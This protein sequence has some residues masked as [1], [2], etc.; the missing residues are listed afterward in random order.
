MGYGAGRGPAALLGAQG[1][2]GRRS[3]ALDGGRLYRRLAAPVQRRSWHPQSLAGGLPAHLL[4]QFIDQPNQ[5]IL[6]LVSVSSRLRP[7]SSETFFW[8]SIILAAWCSLAWSR[9]FSRLSSR[10]A[11]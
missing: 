2:F 10:S 4:S 5:L 9:S 3:R 11:A 6:S 8:T 7:R 1:T